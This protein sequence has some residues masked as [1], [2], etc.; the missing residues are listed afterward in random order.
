MFCG[1]FV[2]HTS[3]EK[4]DSQTHPYKNEKKQIY[5]TEYKKKNAIDL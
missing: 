2:G 1:R 4:K 5:L 3:C